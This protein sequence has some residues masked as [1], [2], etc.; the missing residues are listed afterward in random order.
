LL[1]ALY[2]EA[3]AANLVNGYGSSY[4]KSNHPIELFF[5][6]LEAN[7]VKK[8]NSY[9]NEKTTETIIEHEPIFYSSRFLKQVAIEVPVDARY[10]Q[11]II[12]S[13]WLF[14]FAAG[15][16]MVKFALDTG[17]GELNSLGFGFMNIQREQQ[18]VYN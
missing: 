18:E 14:R 3:G 5:N 11:T 10:R 2:E 9:H 7:L 6:Q 16:D 8:Y 15:N 13:K 12:G 4:W 17:L 1:D